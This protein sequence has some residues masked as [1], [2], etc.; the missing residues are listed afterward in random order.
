MPRFQCPRGGVYSRPMAITTTKLPFDPIKLVC[1]VGIDLE[2]VPFAADLVDRERCERVVF[3]LP[4]RDY[5]AR[6]RDLAEQLTVP[7]EFAAVEGEWPA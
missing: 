6:Q 1:S 5:H 2:L 4:A 3:V 7:F